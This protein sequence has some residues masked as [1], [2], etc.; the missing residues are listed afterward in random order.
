MVDKLNIFTW[1]KAP[2]VLFNFVN[3]NAAVKFR[4]FVF[5]SVSTFVLPSVIDVCGSLDL[6]DVQEDL[7][8][9]FVLNRILRPGAKIYKKNFMLTVAQFSAVVFAAFFIL[10][11]DPKGK[12]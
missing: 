6:F 10:I 11:Q 2:T 5:S 3:D 12:S 4:N 9:T 7:L 1:D 8:F